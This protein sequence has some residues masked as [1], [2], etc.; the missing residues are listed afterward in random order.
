L[1]APRAGENESGGRRMKKPTP[2]SPRKRRDSG[3]PSVTMGVSGAEL[4]ARRD[5]RL[6]TV[7]LLGSGRTPLPLVAVAEEAVRGADKAVRDALTKEPPRASV[8]CQE[9]CA[10]CCYQTV[11]TAAP[12]VLRIAAHLR[13]TLAPE[14]MRTTQARIRE[15]A[16]Q[17][18]A[19]RP[20]RR[21]RARLPCALLVENR[22]TAYDVRPLTCRGFNSYDARQCERSLETGNAARVPCYAPQRRLCTFVLDGMRAGLEECRI[23]GELLELTAA[24]DIALTT[25][26]AAERWLAGEAVFA[27]ARLV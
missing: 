6:K 19:L 13:Q 4:E 11:G 21:S 25:P 2:G 24:L 12:E 9:G 3:A 22:C 14:E 15:R 16:E 5:Q 10:W 23:D 7:A 20:D 26:D 8:A 27:S 18:R 17:R 1:L